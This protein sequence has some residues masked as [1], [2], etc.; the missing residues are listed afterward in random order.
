[1][2]G[3]ELGSHGLEHMPLAGADEN[4]ARGE[5]VDSRRRLEAALGVRVATFAWPYGA[6][7][8]ATAARFIAQT[9]DAACAAGPAVVR[10]SSDPLALPRVDI[11]Y[12]RSPDRLRHAL[13]REPAFWLSLRG[14]A[15]R[16]RRAFRPDYSSPRDA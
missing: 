7:P 6:K 15:A 14:L 4:D 13:E 10:N 16:A 9:Y 8:S 12:L 5:V 2:A 11:H 1:V 3:W